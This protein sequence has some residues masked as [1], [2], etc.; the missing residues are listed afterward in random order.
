VI[1]T[2]SVGRTVKALHSSTSRMCRRDPAAPRRRSSQIW[3]MRP[4]SMATSARAITRSVPSST[5]IQPR[6]LK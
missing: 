5:V 6:V 1:A 2:I 4:A 3:V